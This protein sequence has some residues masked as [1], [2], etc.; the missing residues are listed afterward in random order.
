M[1][2]R[3]VNDHGLEELILETDGHLCVAFLSHTSAP[4]G[5]FAPEFAALA[6][7]LRDRMASAVLD[8][9][10]NPSIT[11]ECRV[12]AVPTTVLFLGGRE[13]ARWEGPYNRE[14]LKGRIT[15]AMA[16]EGKR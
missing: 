14:A 5:H 1:T 7:A 15:D 4:C 6:A 12:T 16:R 10:E 8:A 11:D 3:R 13:V 2:V 9:D